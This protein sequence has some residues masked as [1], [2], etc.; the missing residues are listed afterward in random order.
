[1]ECDKE[2]TFQG[3]LIWIVSAATLYQRYPHI[4]SEL[5]HMMKIGFGADEYP[6]E[7]NDVS[8]DLKDMSL[9]EDEHITLVLYAPNCISSEHIAP[10]S[11]F[12]TLHYVPHEHSVTMWNLCSID[13]GKG[14]AGRLVDIATK[15]T[16]SVHHVPLRLKVYVYNTLF[17]Q[18]VS[19]YL[20]RGFGL[21]HIERKGEVVCMIQDTPSSYEHIIHQCWQ[22]VLTQSSS[23]E[24]IWLTRRLMSLMPIRKN[25]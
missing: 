4:S 12:L 22:K 10:I 19:F 7:K 14:Y 5:E 24:R 23:P 21:E 2:I 15:W 16:N 17:H 20:R 1:M 11:C 3:D 13:R 25:N 6:G 9:T 8:F 18:V